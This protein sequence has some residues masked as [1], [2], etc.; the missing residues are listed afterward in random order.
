MASWRYGYGP[1]FERKLE[2]IIIETLRDIMKCL[3][4]VE[5]WGAVNDGSSKILHLDGYILSPKAFAYNTPEK[6]TKKYAGD[7]LTGKF[8]QNQ[9]IQSLFSAIYVE[10]YKASYIEA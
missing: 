3:L 1:R 7:R 10:D 5:C 2:D 9:M 4:K 8:R 6:P